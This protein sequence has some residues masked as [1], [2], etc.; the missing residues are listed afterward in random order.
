MRDIKHYCRA[1]TM[2]FETTNRD[3]AHR[4]A[5]VHYINQHDMDR[6]FERCSRYC[7]MQAQPEEI[8]RGEK[9]YGEGSV[10][11]APATPGTYDRLFPEEDP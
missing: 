6:Q 10:R 8:K 9:L 7:E 4:L 5:M 11:L 3:S 1:C 2:T